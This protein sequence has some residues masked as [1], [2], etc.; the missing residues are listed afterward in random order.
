MVSAKRKPVDTS[1]FL[2]NPADLLADQYYEVY[3]ARLKAARESLIKSSRFRWGDE[4]K[5]VLLEQLNASLG[6]TDVFVIGTLFKSMP[7]QPSILRELEE[8]VAT[9]DDPSINFTS[10]EDTL[11]L[12]ETD[13][14]VRIVGDIDVHAHVTGIPVSLLGHQLNGGAKFHVNDICYAGA[15]LSVYK[16]PPANSYIDPKLKGQKILIVSGLQ[17]GFDSV[18]NQ[19]ES[20][21]IIH[22]LEKLRDLILKNGCNNVDKEEHDYTIAKIIIAGNCAAK[23]LKTTRAELL[24]GSNKEETNQKLWKFYQMFDKYLFT[25]AQSGA[26]VVLM[27]G[28]Y[29]PT[30]NLL[31]Q[32]P[33]HPRLLP[34][35]GVLSNVKPITNPCIVNHEDYVLLGTS[36]ETIEAI[37]QYSKIE[38]S[39]TVMKNTLEWGHI[40]PSAPDNLSCIPFKEKD[41]FILD[42]VPDIYFAGN[43]TEYA[44]SEYCTETKSKIQII[45]VPSFVDNPSCVLVDLSTLEPNLVSL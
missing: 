4:V 26:D 29:D 41:P 25:L 24:G 19:A 11:I 36:G 34:Q 1:R 23:S 44:I 9:P 33:V 13:E 37:K 43:Q 3:N 28:K 38:F 39:T 14:N 32:Q 35:S 15:N 45:S 2:L 7:K 12:H 20:T 16:M 17:F 6:S 40:A 10:D 27:P 22:G 31:P 21:R 42:F 18:L 30:T 5:N 8:N